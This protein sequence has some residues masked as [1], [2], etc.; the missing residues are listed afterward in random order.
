M[1]LLLLILFFFLFLALQCGFYMG[2]VILVKLTSLIILL[3]LQHVALEHGLVLVDTKYEFG[4]GQ[5]G[6]VLLIDE[7]YHLL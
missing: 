7:V 5:D 2:F 1:Q 4:K 3:I 6:S